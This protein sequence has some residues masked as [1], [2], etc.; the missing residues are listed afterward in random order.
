MKCDICNINKES[1]IVG[2]YPEVNICE[3]CYDEL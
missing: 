1:Y 2:R 3:E